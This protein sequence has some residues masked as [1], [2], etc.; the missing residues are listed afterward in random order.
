MWANNINL[1]THRGPPRIR[2][3]GSFSR[4]V[5][6]FNPFHIPFSAIPFSAGEKKQPRLYCSD[7]FYSSAVTI[8]VYELSP[9]NMADTSTYFCFAYLAIRCEEHNEAATIK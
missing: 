7:T 1:S 8:P 9:R 3:P 4:R 5:Q 2:L 6:N